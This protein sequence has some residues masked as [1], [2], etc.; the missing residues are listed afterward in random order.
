MQHAQPIQNVIAVTP[1]VKEPVPGWVDNLNGP[2]G[3]LVG[4]GKG[5]I[6]SMHCKAELLAQII[7]VDFAINGMIITAWKVGTTKEKYVSIILIRY[8]RL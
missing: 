4:G 6:R 8:H 1:S 5:V 2:I 3:L 7:P